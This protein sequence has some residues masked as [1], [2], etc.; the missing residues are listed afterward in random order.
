MHFSVDSLI[1]SDSTERPVRVNA[2]GISSNAPPVAATAAAP[3]VASGEGRGDRRSD[4]WERPAV[5][6]EGNVE[7][8]PEV[9]GCLKTALPFQCQLLISVPLLS[10]F[11]SV[12]LLQ[13]LDSL[14]SCNIC[15]TISW[16]ASVT[17][18]HLC[19]M[20]LSHSSPLLF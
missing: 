20:A 9:S 1:A 8:L 17:R 14:T 12:S 2:P 19:C 10:M 13:C 5:L 18:M 16:C 7:L 4:R 11:T 3:R 6:G 15:T